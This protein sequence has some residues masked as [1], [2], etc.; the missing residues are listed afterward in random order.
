MPDRD[1]GRRSPDVRGS[2]SVSDYPAPLVPVEPRRA[3]PPPHPGL[4]RRPDDRRHDRRPLRVGMAGL[5]AVLHPAGRRRARRR[6]STRAR[7]RRPRVATPSTSGCGWATSTGPARPRCSARPRSRASTTPSAS[8]GRRST[9]GSRRTSRSSSTRAA[10]TRGSMRCGRPAPCA[11]SRTGVVLAESSSPVMLLRDRPPDPLLPEP[12]RRRLHAPRAVR[13]GD[14]LPLQGHDE[15]L[16]VGAR[17]RT[18]S[19]PTSPG[20]TTS[21]PARCSPSPA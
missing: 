20:P 19:I 10:R 1:R 3:R 14:R 2:G 13:H 12:D 9:P 15:R 21:R 4:P 5:P 11:S 8:S 18:G 16:L 17:S 6:W 7:P